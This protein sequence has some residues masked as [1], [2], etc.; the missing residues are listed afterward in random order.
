MVK[1]T[2]E[3]GQANNEP[4]DHS[5]RRK[6]LRVQ[7]P[8]KARFLDEAG[9]ERP[10]LVVNVSAG[11]ALLRT[12]NPP[13][14]G[15]SVVLYID[16]LGR[17]EGRVIRSGGT[18]FAINYEKKR[19]KSARVADDITEVMHKGKRSLDRRNT[20]RLRHNAPAIIH[21]EDGRTEECAILD[22][23]LTGAS[24]AVNPR[25]PLGMRLILGRMTA[26]VVRRHETGV[27][28]VFTG[29]AENIDDIITET[30]A[31][32]VPANPGAGFAPPFGKKGAGA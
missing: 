18:S 7:L 4:V 12:K 16:R 29:A 10:C 14:F 25:P 31:T 20:P 17:F 28:V 27:G 24:I 2:G 32:D 5:D 1:N 8:L 3:F 13:A 6:H 19:E 23:S 26:K 30:A 21:F 11:G 22:I 9:E 15:K